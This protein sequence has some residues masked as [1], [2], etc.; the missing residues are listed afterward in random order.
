MELRNFLWIFCTF[1]SD[2]SQFFSQDFWIHTER[3]RKGIRRIVELFRVTSDFSLPDEKSLAL[4]GRR[5]K[6]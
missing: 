5:D 3:L 2:R 1:R 6:R 4:T